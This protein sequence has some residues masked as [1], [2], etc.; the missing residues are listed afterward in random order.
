MKV[1]KTLTALMVMG[2]A[3]ATPLSANAATG[4]TVRAKL[5]GSQ[6]VPG[7]GDINGKG[8]FKATV[9]GDQFCYKLSTSKIAGV[10]DVSIYAGGAGETGDVVVMLDGFRDASGC[11]TVVPDADDTAATLSESEAAAILA[12]PG[13]YYVEVRSKRYPN[14]VLRGQLN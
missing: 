8:S 5:T 6:V 4:G 10:T 1:G 13:Q 9:D 11:L 14:G 7:P 2:L 12:D 3:V